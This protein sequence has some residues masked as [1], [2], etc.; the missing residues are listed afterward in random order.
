MNNNYKNNYIYQFY[1]QNSSYRKYCYVNNKNNLKYF[2]NIS[3][4]A[5]FLFTSNNKN[6]CGKLYAKLGDCYY[7]INSAW[8]YDKLPRVYPK[9]LYSIGKLIV[10][11]KESKNLCKVFRH[12]SYYYKKDR[13]SKIY[14][15][16][17]NKL[18]L[19]NKIIQNIDC[20][21]HYF[22]D[23]PEKTITAKLEEI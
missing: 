23:Y 11:G 3:D 6:Y 4:L 15:I 14:K 8:V 20:K 2:D 10:V 16:L 12:K 9:Y 17:K 19:R 13:N 22:F 18:Y 7:S 21:Y 5:I 1:S